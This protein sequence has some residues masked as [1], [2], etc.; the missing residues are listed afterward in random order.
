MKRALLCAAVV[1]AQ[2]LAVTGVPA[3]ATPDTAPVALSPDAPGIA[4]HLG[5]PVEE[6]QR[7]ID[8]QDDAGRLDQLAA[9]T[10]PETF[11]GL[12]IDQ[13]DGASVNVAF[14][15]DAEANVAALAKQF[16]YPASLRARSATRS[17]ASLQ[18]VQRRMYDDRKLVDAGRLR[19]FPGVARGSYVTDID[20]P[21]NEIVAT[22]PG[23]TD[24]TW[25]AFAARYGAAVR[26]ERGPIGETQACGITACK[27]S[28][29]SGV[30][31]ATSG[32]YA[33][34]LAFTVYDTSYNRRVL[35]AG[36]CGG[37]SDNGSSR[38]HYLQQYGTVVGQQVGNSAVDAEW[39]SVDQNGFY[40]GGWIL[41]P[42]STET[43]SFTTWGTYGGLAVGATVCMTGN[44]SGYKCGTVQSKTHSPNTLDIPNGYNF[45]K[46]T[47]C[48]AGGDSGAGV[49]VNGQGEGIHSGA[50][51]AT[52]CGNAGWYSFFGHIE[53][54]LVSLGVWNTVS[55]SSEP[56]P[57]MSTVS[58]AF[59]GMS[60]VQANFSKPVRCSSVQASDF[61]VTVS[62]VARSITAVDCGG[63]SVD[64][65]RT[66]VLT[67]SSTLTTGQT[68]AVTIGNGVTDS[69]GIVS[70]ANTRTTTT[71]TI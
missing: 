51:T 33:C 10:W 55:G 6:A 29:R 62:G 20:V 50:T 46:T 16:A 57:D 12:W 27:Y 37:S 36:H 14:T 22:A 21:T 47:I 68:V 59:N 5:V 35:S 54:A 23:A 9:A 52:T 56:S 70:L 64:S 19:A 63:T 45:V 48:S 61:S 4:A 58:G 65:N 41:V 8:L 26:V 39:H 13:A 3:S 66:I 15:R 18:A 49:Y 24:D 67:L 34:T 32:N 11:A 69:A 30:Q 40:A 2:V 44:T 28:L 60:R 38:S 43:R 31:T 17:L 42:G 7:R 1:A 71:T 53:H 25:A